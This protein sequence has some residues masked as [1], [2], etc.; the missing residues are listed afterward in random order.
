MPAT[1]GRD[2]RLEH[3]GLRSEVDSAV[4][5]LREQLF[6]GEASIYRIVSGCGAASGIR[7]AKLAGR[8]QSEVPCGSDRRRNER[9]EVRG[10]VG[11]DRQDA[12]RNVRTRTV[13]GGSRRPAAQGVECRAGYELVSPAGWYDRAEAEGEAGVRELDGG[14]GS[15]GQQR[16]VAENHHGRRVR[17]AEICEWWQR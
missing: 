9:D 13:D 4:G 2:D 7:H 3:L 16:V 12:A 17:S 10:K 8:V 14:R 15:R 5:E 11:P 6:R 1:V